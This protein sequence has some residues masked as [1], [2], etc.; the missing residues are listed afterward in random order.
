MY[1]M[2]SSAPEPLSSDSYRPPTPS[3]YENQNLQTVPSAPVAGQWGWGEQARVTE[4]T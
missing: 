2:M 3:H 4:L 1:G